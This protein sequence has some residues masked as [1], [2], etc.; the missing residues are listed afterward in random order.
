MAGK[1][2]E[3]NTQLRADIDKKLKKDFQVA[4]VEDEKHIKTVL[5][6]LIVMYLKARRKK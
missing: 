1:K 2:K 4:C 3:L 6:E 5:T